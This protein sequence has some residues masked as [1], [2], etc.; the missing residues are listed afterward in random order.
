MKALKTTPFKST[1]KITLGVDKNGNKT[2]L[3]SPGKGQ[4]GFSKQTNQ[5]G[6]CLYHAHRMAPS[7]AAGNQLL[8][9]STLGDFVAKHGKQREWLLIANS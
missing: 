5:G 4:R 8:L 1:F 9:R 2:I 6:G 7:E 3:F